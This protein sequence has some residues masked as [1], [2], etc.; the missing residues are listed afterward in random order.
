MS[1]AHL[2]N[3]K[4]WSLRKHVV[5][6]LLY[7]LLILKIY[8]WMTC[9][10]SVLLNSITRKCTLLILQC[11]IVLLIYYIWKPQFYVSFDWYI[12]NI[13]SHV[14]YY[15]ADKET[16]E[17]LETENK[18][19]KEKVTE[20]ENLSPSSGKKHPCKEFRQSNCYTI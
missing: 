14:L 5:N 20:L 19:L 12:S 9:Q 6:E 4:E 10:T 18:R 3:P 7:C 8:L 17:Q 15:V 2:K 13:L 1:R 16:I 11:N